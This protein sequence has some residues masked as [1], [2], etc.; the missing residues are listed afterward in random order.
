MFDI[1]HTRKKESRNTRFE[2]TDRHTESERVRECMS[3][4]NDREKEQM[5]K[6][7]WGSREALIDWHRL[8]EFKLDSLEHMYGKKDCYYRRYKNERVSE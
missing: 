7:E 6:K 8:C 3:V 5:R 4:V 2:E 1:T